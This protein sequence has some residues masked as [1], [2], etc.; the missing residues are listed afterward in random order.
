MGGKGS[1]GRNKKSIEAHK[2]AGTYRRDRHGP[3]KSE[4]KVG[5]MDL[6]PWDHIDLQSGVGRKLTEEE[7]QSLRSVWA[8][9][10]GEFLPRPD[11][12]AGSTFEDPYRSRPGDRPWMWW[13]E[14]DLLAPRDM[15]KEL[16]VLKKLGALVKGEWEA[17]RAD[18]R[19]MALRHWCSVEERE[20]REQE[21]A[22][23]LG[24]PV[25]WVREW[26]ASDKSTGKGE[27]EVN[28]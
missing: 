7:W 25:A 22:D 6:G 2:L 12:L 8:R 1:G 16:L 13:A 14:R 10:Q 17:A 3:K 19:R 24:V 15:G 11:R 21:T 9:V 4:V 26:W 5:A 23:W 27:V 18:F 28:A 20:G